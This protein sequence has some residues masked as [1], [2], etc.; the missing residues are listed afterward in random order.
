MFESLVGKRFKSLEELEKAMEN[1]CGVKVNC[2]E[3]ESEMLPDTD[4]MI[5]YEIEDD[6]DVYTLFYLKG[7]GECK[8]Y[9]TEV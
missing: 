8:Y 5:D 3:S 1:I 4:Y 6:D 9:I 2:I 7:R